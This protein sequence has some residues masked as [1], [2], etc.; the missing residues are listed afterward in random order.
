MADDKPSNDAPKADAKKSKAGRKP[1][2]ML[3][4]LVAALVSGLLGGGVAYGF[5]YYGGMERLE[6]ANAEHAAVQ[7]VCADEQAALRQKLDDAR[8]DKRILEVRVSLAR[9][10]D[11]LAQRNFGIAEKHLARAEAIGRRIETGTIFMNRADYLD[12]ALCWTGC[13]DTGRGAGLSALGYHALTR[14]KSYHLKKV[15]S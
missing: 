14:P 10:L 1:N 3:T 6:A 13:K 4:G 11:E 12:P 2:A 8:Q 5:A 15:T 7:K 9:L